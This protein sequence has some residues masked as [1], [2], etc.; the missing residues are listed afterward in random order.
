IPLSLTAKHLTQKEFKTY[1]RWY[2][3]ILVR[4]NQ[5][6]VSIADV[7]QFL[8]NFRISADIK[9]AINRIFSKIMHLINIGEFYALL[10]VI[11]HALQGQ[12]PSRAL[13]R[14]L[15]A[16]PTPP[17]ILCKK[18]LKDD[19]NSDGDADLH[20]PHD[21]KDNDGPLD[22]DLFTQF[23]LTGERPTQTKKRQKK[24]KTVKFSDQVETTYRDLDTPSLANAQSTSLDYSLPMDQLLSR[25]NAS[26]TQPNSTFAV[27]EENPGPGPALDPEEKQILRDME[28]QINH[29]QNLHSVDTILV[30]GVPATIHVQHNSNFWLPCNLL[31]Q[32]PLLKPNMTGPV[33][34]AQMGLYNGVRLGESDYKYDPTLENAQRMA[35]LFS[36]TPE[37][38]P[39][40]SLETFTSQMTGDQ[41]PTMKS[42]LATRLG[43][44]SPR[45]EAVTSR[46]RSVSL[47]PIPPV[48]PRVSPV[49]TGR[50]APPPPRARK[51]SQFV[52]IPAQTLSNQPPPLPVKAPNDGFYQ[53]RENNSTANILDDLKALQE[54]VDKIRDLTGGF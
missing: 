35:Q 32:P 18:R 24:P 43:A 3:D 29:F 10:R 8:G 11:S 28:S 6:T 2:S 51:S 19:N 41:E 4:T 7:Y 20:H 52:A 38:V 14:V 13:I 9:D 54:E 33:Q 40:L 17:S 26:K 46:Q 15:T 27:P 39:K 22:I 30:G 12:T 45:T 1:L 53:S 37:E 21:S 47:S 50:P 48:P 16:V 42:P 25:M 23:M 34:M 44:A 49:T 5:R 36:P 31:L